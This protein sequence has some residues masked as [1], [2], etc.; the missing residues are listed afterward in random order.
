MSDEAMEME[1][2]VGGGA[3]TSIKCDASGSTLNVIYD[4][5]PNNQPVT[6]GNFFTWWQN[7]DQVPWGTGIVNGKGVLQ[8]NTPNVLQAIANIYVGRNSYIVAWAVGGDLGNIVANH[9]P[10]RSAAARDPASEPALS[11]ESMGSN[12]VVFN[13]TLPTG[14]TPSTFKH[15][16]GVWEGTV[17]SYTVA[18][19]NTAP[20]TDNASDS[21]VA[22]NGID[23][24]RAARTPPPTSPAD[25]P[26]QIPARRRWP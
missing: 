10:P 8:T 6:F 5:L 24:R 7:A 4:T 23:L 26:R 14:S 20:V 12:S 15:W 3:T 9:L 2:A 13:Y 18:P 17:A 19:K 25:G 21:A 11:V 1:A 22:V 16:V